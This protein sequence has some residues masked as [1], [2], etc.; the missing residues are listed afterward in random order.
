MPAIPAPSTTEAPGPPRPAGPPE[1]AAEPAPRSGGLAAGLVREARPKQWVK[2]VLVLTAP[3]AAGKIGHAATVRDGAI[4]LAAFC[5]AASAVYYANDSFDV[6]AD[7]QHPK[8]RFRPIAAG[9]I[10]IRLAW[11]MVALLSA[12]AVAVGF[13]ANGATAAVI[14]F[15]IAM[16]LAYSAWFKHVAVVD[17][18]MVAAG[19][20]LRAMVGGIAAGLP[21][22]QWFLLT[23]GFGSLFMVAGKRYSE[24]VLMG[25]EAA[26]TRKSL[27]AYSKSYLR[28]VWQMAAG[29]T[30]LTYAEWASILD[31]GHHQI[32]W[33]EISIVP[34]CLVFLRYALLVDRGKA[35]EPEDVV[36]GDRMIKIVGALWLVC[37]T[38]GVFNVR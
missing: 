7:R 6:E 11:V 38:L 37:F 8:K 29:L 2:N 34:W 36:L 9:I 4:A 1:S 15:Y 10:P 31:A 17:L 16:H 27:A 22:S 13:A 25:E 28:F 21:L 33:H 32:A 3:L 5:L 26:S 18:V 14:G 19:F 30:M 20:L 24:M 35:G 12:A 23:T